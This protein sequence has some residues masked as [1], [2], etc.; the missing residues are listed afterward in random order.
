L[1]THFKALK[2]EKQKA[3]IALLSQLQLQT[4]QIGKQPAKQ[5]NISPVNQF[6]LPTAPV[7]QF[8]P[9]TAAFI[10]ASRP[11]IYQPLQQFNPNNT[12]QFFNPAFELNDRLCSGFNQMSSHFKN[13]LFN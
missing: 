4:K 13:S 12:C 9:Y 7:P 5:F 6:I 3:K 1:E 10:S 2:E 11:T 8:A